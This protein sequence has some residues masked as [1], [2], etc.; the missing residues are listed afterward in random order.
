M[1][2]THNYNEA[3]RMM[4]QARVDKKSQVQLLV[5]MFISNYGL[6]I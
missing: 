4:F 1:V 5:L 3:F 6:E 2:L